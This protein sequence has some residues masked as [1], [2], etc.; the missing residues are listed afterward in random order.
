MMRGFALALMILWPTTTLANVDVMDLNIPS[1]RLPDWYDPKPIE[2]KHIAAKAWP[3]F[4]VTCTTAPCR[5]GAEPFT[6]HAPI[7]TCSAV[8]T[9]N[10]NGLDCM[11]DRAGNNVVLYLPSGDY[12]MPQ[13]LTIQRGDLVLRGAGHQN[14][15]LRRTTT[16]RTTAPGCDVNRAGATLLSICSENKNARPD[17]D[18][19]SGYNVGDVTLGVANTATFAPGQWVG[20][21][22]APIMACEL[23]D[24]LPSSLRDLF[25]HMA[26][27]TARSTS[28]GPGT[29]T[30]D[31]PLVM[32]YVGTG[33]TG[34][35]IRPMNP[36]T[37]LGIE[38]LR[39]YTDPGIPMCTESTSGCSS[40]HMYFSHVSTENVAESWFVGVKLER[41]YNRVMDLQY[42]ARLWIQGG[43]IEEVG[44]NIVD[45]SEGQM[46]RAVTDIVYENIICSNT[47]VCHQ[48]QQSAESVVYAYGY[49]D[50]MG[51]GAAGKCQGVNS[52]GHEKGLF[53]HG[54]YARHALFE[55][56]DMD[57][58]IILADVWWSRNGPFHTAYRN[59]LRVEP[60][61]GCSGPN[62]G[63]V[64]VDWSGGTGAAADYGTVIGNTA[65]GYLGRPATGPDCANLN[66]WVGMDKIITHLWIEKN[67]FRNPQSSACSASE[68][69]YC[70][71]KVHD[72]T[73]GRINNAIT[74]CGTGEGDACPGT[75]KLTRG[76]DPSWSGTYPTSFYRKSA[77]TWWCQEA[78]AWDQTGIGA[79]GDDFDATLC[80]L[81]AQIRYEG[82][83][84]TPL[85]GGGGTT[86]T[87]P[88]APVLFN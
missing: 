32:D 55:G 64:T 77:P 35:A 49:F 39:L 21:K 11:I 7:A 34:H 67:A 80:K 5:D 79:F 48:N 82:G 60:P 78:C 27:V 23:V 1:S 43:W 74:S 8:S 17:V 76:P 36:V 45:S 4:D 73:N 70:A 29:I 58:R 41:A 87:R 62:W 37:N 61:H 22:M 42:S 86:P 31:R 63:F 13:A 3:K 50:N 9:S 20:I 14:T 38:D 71:F 25:H 66:P 88:V 52:C 6:N 54:F 85:S 30:I 44:L 68:Q 28:S 57:G 53:N 69:P 47:R 56:N 75:N 18:W 72:D 19:T 59:R 51:I 24:I 65:Q 83:T 15:T 2:D 10:A 46:N 84:C 81:P 26:K 12:P 16:G 40:S 33:C